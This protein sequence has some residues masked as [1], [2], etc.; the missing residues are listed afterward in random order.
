MY[1]LR[2]SIFTCPAVDSVSS[3]EEVWY[4]ADE[5]VYDENTRTYVSSCSERGKDAARQEDISATKLELA[6]NIP[7][8]GFPTK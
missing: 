8:V 6:F 4:T 1:L 7:E 3:D 2:A 5:G